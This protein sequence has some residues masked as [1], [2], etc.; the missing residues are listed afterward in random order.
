MQKTAD[1][2]LKLP[3]SYIKITDDTCGFTQNEIVECLC[4]FGIKTEKLT[5]D[6][7]YEEELEIR[8]EYGVNIKLGALR[9]AQSCLFVAKTEDDAVF[10]CYF[11]TIAENV[12]E[13]FR[14]ISYF[15]SEQGRS[16]D[17][18]Y[19]IIRENVG[20]FLPADYERLEE[21]ARTKVYLLNLHSEEM[22]KE[23][24]DFDSYDITCKH[25]PLRS[26][27]SLKTYLESL[28]FTPYTGRV[29]RL[30]GEAV[31][32]KNYPEIFKRDEK[33]KLISRLEVALRENPFKQ[34]AFYRCL[35]PKYPIREV[36]VYHENRLISAFDTRQ[37]NICGFVVVPAAI[38]VD[39]CKT[40]IENHHEDV[41]LQRIIS[42]ILRKHGNAQQEDPS[43]WMR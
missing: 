34:S 24:V 4:C 12:G 22:V 10:V 43:R 7:K 9:I 11:S 39:L 1:Q 2:R 20:R 3:Y 35:S 13:R 15:I 40:K 37:A 38:A 8:K 23:V 29:L 18:N 32:F 21:K 36:L 19:H 33:E 14:I 27:R 42:G 25:S 30:E 31:R 16:S 17:V 41:I 6:R 5:T 26:F 28:Y